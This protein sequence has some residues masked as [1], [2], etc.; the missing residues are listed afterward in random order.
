[1]YIVLGNFCDMHVL[2]QEFK[3]VGHHAWRCKQ[4]LD[5]FRNSDSEPKDETKNC[6]SSVFVL[7]RINSYLFGSKTLLWKNVKWFPWFENA[8]SWLHY[9]GLSEETFEVLDKD[10]VYND[11]RQTEENIDFTSTPN[12]GPDVKLLNTMSSW[13]QYLLQM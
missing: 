9:Q 12:T 8:S 1:M 11:T 13:S 5:S 6:N 4:K 7:V 10:K 3:S 2:W